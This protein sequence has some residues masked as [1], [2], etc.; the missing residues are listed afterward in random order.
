MPR[1]DSLRTTTKP[2]IRIVNA[3]RVTE[4][5][6]IAAL[7]RASVGRLREALPKA[8]AMQ[9]T[10]EGA[11]DDLTV[12]ARVRIASREYIGRARRGDLA[13]AM[14]GAL[15]RL[16]SKLSDADP[17]AVS[18]PRRRP[19]G[20]SRLGSAARDLTVEDRSYFDDVVHEHLGALARFID[21]ELTH[22]RAAGL[23]ALDYPSVEDVV[24]DTLVRAL[25][26]L[27]YRTE[28]MPVFSWLAAHAVRVLENEATLARRRDHEG[29]SGVALRRIRR[30]HDFEDGTEPLASS[31]RA[32]VSSTLPANEEANAIADPGEW[33]L[34]VEEVRGYLLETLADLP[35]RWRRAVILVHMDEQPP[36]AVASVL[37]ADVE[38]LQA[39][40]EHAE[41]FLRARLAEDAVALPEAVS[42]AQCLQWP[43]LPVGYASD[44]EAHLL[45]RGN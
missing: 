30:L 1:R 3:P 10:V 6:V 38:E 15:G 28:V 18:S 17:G 39:M 25:E 41:A 2:S 40:L 34:A 23:I 37:G 8:A 43:E 21:Q 24:D 44:L 36:S 12:T 20:R 14:Q 35:V 19:F 42:P 33:T 5:A 29:L 11:G 31:A 27:P 13:G 26:D 45:P 22:L 9:I 32:A 4:D 16:D 7:A